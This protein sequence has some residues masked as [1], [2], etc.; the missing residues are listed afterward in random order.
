MPNASQKLP[1]IGD[2]QATEPAKRRAYAGLYLAVLHDRRMCLC[3]MLVAEYRTLPEQ[4][5]LR[6]VRFF[7]ENHTWLAGMLEAGRADGSLSYR[8]A[9]TD[10]AQTIVGAPEGAMD[11]PTRT[12]RASKPPPI[13]CLPSS[14]ARKMSSERAGT[15]LCPLRP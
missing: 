4:M 12:Q 9:A 1:D 2:F 11:A 10:A 5:R 8:G 3:G 7:D 6:V 13:S 14:R 15:D